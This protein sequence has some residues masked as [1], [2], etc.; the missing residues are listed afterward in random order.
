MITTILQSLPPCPDPQPAYN[1]EAGDL[2]IPG[3]LPKD[4]SVER[5]TQV[6]HEAAVDAIDTN[7]RLLEE[8]GNLRLPLLDREQLSAGDREQLNRVRGYFVVVR[9]LT[10]LLWLLP[11]GC[12][13]LI[14]VL[15]VR[16]I[17]EWGQWWGWPMLVGGAF[18]LALALLLPAALLLLVPSTMTFTAETS[19]LR[20]LMSTFLR[21]A[22]DVLVDLWLGRV[23]LQAGVMAVAGVL[24]VIIGFATRER[25]QLGRP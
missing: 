14:A 1:L 21:Q 2:E 12:L 19:E 17:S 5:A 23:Y 25:Q 3:C 9:R 15:A 10:G 11:L 20:T 7:P 22:V 24:L 6:I 16:S 8:M 4:V 18:A 13:I